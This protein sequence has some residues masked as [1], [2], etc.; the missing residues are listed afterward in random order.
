MNNSCEMYL[1]LPLDEWIIILSC[2]FSHIVFLVCFLSYNWSNSWLLPLYIILLKLIL[3]MNKFLFNDVK[4]WFLLT[5]YIYNELFVYYM[6]RVMSDINLPVQNVFS[7]SGIFKLQ[8]HVSIV[9]LKYILLSLCSYQIFLLFI[10]F[11]CVC[12]YINI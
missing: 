5:L 8:W 9:S 4:S 7:I 6:Y 12:I 1:Y 11:K 2:A 3:L 10:V